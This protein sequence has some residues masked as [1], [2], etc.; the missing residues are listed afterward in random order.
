MR[1]PETYEASL[2]V[3]M[4]IYLGASFFTL[5]LIL[6]AVFDPT[7]RVLHTLQALIYVVVILLV[8]R[9]NVWG[10]G[11]A[12]FIAVLW[13]YTNL[14]ITT[15]IKAGWTQL[16]A[17]LRTGHLPRPDSLI[18]LLAAGGHF[19]MIGA[20]LAGFLLLRPKLMGWLKFLAGGAAAIA[21]FVLIIYTTGPQYIPLV[22]RIF[23][24]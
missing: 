2:W 23:H 16:V 14:F 15:F 11:A 22:R 5:A 7:I 19:L 9:S 20:G 10:Y 4:P 18:A 1:F 6:S 21:Y 24:L 13:N 12:F 3:R 8:K 17:F